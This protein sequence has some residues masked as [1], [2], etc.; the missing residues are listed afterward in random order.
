[1]DIRDKFL[2]IGVFVFILI[3]IGSSIY[4][5]N[6]CDPQWQAIEENLDYIKNPNSIIEIKLF[7]AHTDFDINLTNDTVT[8]TDPADIAAIQKMINDRYPG[9][10]NRPIAS[11]NTYMKL[12]LANNRNFE[13]KVCKIENDKSPHMTHLYFGSKHCRD[14]YPNC[15][16]TLGTYLENL[17]AYT[18]AK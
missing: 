17:T 12:S 9:T 4:D 3:G 15:S 11:W 10:W 6:V 1:M 2:I 8:I 18:L 16:Q 13:F 5:K 14:Q 7:K